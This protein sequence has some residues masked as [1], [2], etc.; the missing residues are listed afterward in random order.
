M[1][2]TREEIT[3]EILELLLLFRYVFTDD[4][5]KMLPS[6]QLKFK[7][8]CSVFA[9]IGIEIKDKKSFCD[10][11]FIHQYKNYQFS[12]G[13][14]EA[15]QSSIEG[16]YTVEDIKNKDLKEIIARIIY[17][18][19]RYIELLEGVFGGVWAMGKV[20]VEDRVSKRLVIDSIKDIDVLVE[21][22]N[23]VITQLFF[24]Q[25]NDFNLEILINRYDFP[26]EDYKAIE[27]QERDS[28][29][30]ENGF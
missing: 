6:T 5:T 15:V 20:P 2:I 17:F 12:D 21:R 18:R 24:P 11:E 27:K 14:I 26:Q 16:F 8:I 19:T 10:L 4:P 9:S 7:R 28:F 30:E 22:L 29:Y 1:K 25:M 13:I 23:K 3:I